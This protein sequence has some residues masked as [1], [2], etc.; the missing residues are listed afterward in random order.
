[1]MV[2]A[3]DGI[4]VGDQRMPRVVDSHYCVD[5]G[6]AGQVDR[7]AVQHYCRVGLMRDL[8]QCQVNLL[9]FSRL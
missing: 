4:V 3:I 2:L 1:M 7:E 9:V 5:L 6:M 8:S